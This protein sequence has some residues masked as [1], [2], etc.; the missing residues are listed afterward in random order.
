MT[1][2]MP[3]A[4]AYPLR[5]PEA[6]E[7]PAPDVPYRAPTSKA[8]CPRIGQGSVATAHSTISLCPLKDCRDLQSLHVLTWNTGVSFPLSS[9]ILR[10][11]DLSSLLVLIL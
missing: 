7:F 11:Q 2:A 3:D 9:R 4:D 8:Y 6:P 10:H 5:T 1:E